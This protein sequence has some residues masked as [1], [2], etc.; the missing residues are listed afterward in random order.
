MKTPESTS[1]VD[2]EIVDMVDHVRN[3]YG[4]HGLRQLIAL[5]T[6]EAEDTEGA[7]SE[8]TDAN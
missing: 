2:P 5:A 1:P 4:A 7:L 3:R 6:A 8:L